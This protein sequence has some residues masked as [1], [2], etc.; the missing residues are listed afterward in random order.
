MRILLFSTL[1]PNAAAP[2]HGVF[3]ENRL[4]HL[5]A[6]SGFSAHVL[7]PVPW[8]PP[9]LRNSAAYRA[10]AAAPRSETRHGLH[11]DHPRY[12]VLPRL[13]MSV[14]PLLLYAAAR[15]SLKGLLAAGHR[16]D[17]IDAHYFYPDGVAAALLAREFGL[18]LTITGRGTD[19]TLIPRHRIPRAWLRFAASRADGLITVCAA[20]AEDLARLGV[21]RERV[22]V[23]RNGVDLQQFTETAQG[24]E[25]IRTQVG[26]QSP[27]LAS[28]GHLIERKAHDLVIRAFAELDGGTL[29]IVGTGPEEAALR[30]LAAEMGLEHRVHFLGQVGHERLR[31]IYSAADILMLASSREGWPNVLLEAM[32]CGT[33]VVATAVNGSP[34]VVR[35][36]VAGRIVAERTPEALAA[37]AAELLAAPPSSAAVRRYAEGFSWDATSDGQIAL[38]N[39]IVERH[40]G[41]GR[42]TP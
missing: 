7:A 12:P 21:S 4:R 10:M 17:L 8:V 11:V 22:T 1:F 28:V 3:V 38:F 29:L 33:P 24:R 19:L 26:A 36:P 31:D 30:R 37:A 23:L 18:P 5:L 15:R 27:V 41:E 35:D 2:H 6:R 25:E 9:P 34:E 32:A 20:L 42:A 39:E 13:G 14:A 16:F 40:A